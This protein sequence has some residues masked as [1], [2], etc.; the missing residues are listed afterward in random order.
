LNMEINKA[1]NSPIAKVRH[2]RRR[3][4]QKAKRKQEIRWGVLPV[5]R[6]DGTLDVTPHIASLDMITRGR[7]LKQGKGFVVTKRY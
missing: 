5:R 3:A 7:Y 6:E 4:K 2:D 1:E